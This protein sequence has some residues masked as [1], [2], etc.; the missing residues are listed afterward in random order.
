M[1]WAHLVICIQ[2][3]WIQESQ[4]RAWWI[5][6]YGLWWDWYSNVDRRFHGGFA[7]IAFTTALANN[8]AIACCC[9]GLVVVFYLEHELAVSKIIKLKFFNYLQKS[10]VRHVSSHY[11]QHHQYWMNYAKQHRTDSS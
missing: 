7:V 9:S 2:Y 1:V 5:G 11:V 8:F 3:D 4:L 10:V 6:S